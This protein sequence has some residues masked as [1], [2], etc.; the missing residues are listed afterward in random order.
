M[1]KA[2]E[3]A[4]RLADATNARHRIYHDEK[5]GTPEDIYVIGNSCRLRFGIS[6]EGMP[7]VYMAPED[8]SLRMGGS[9]KFADDVQKLLHAAEWIIETFGEPR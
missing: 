7:T 3:W 5:P 2:S 6:D 9:V 1:S 8:P 4:R